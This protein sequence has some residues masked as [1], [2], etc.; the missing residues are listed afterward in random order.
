MTGGGERVRHSAAFAERIFTQRLLTLFL[1]GYIPTMSC[2]TRGRFPEAILQRTERELAGPGA[3]G[4]VDK[5]G[6]RRWSAGRRSALRH[7]A[8]AVSLYRARWVRYSRLQGVSNATPRAPPAAPSPSRT[9][10]GTGK[11]RTHCAARM[12]K[13]GCLK[14]WIRNARRAATYSPS[15]AGLTRASI[16]LRKGRSKRMDCRVKPGNDE[17]CFPAAM[18]RAALREALLRETPGSLRTMSFVRPRLCSAPGR[19]ERPAALRPGN[20]HRLPVPI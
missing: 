11:P 2:P 15:C 16:H 19:E 10:R 6:G 9:S 8:R 14:L 7:W 1:K 12:Q 4:M 20:G 13:F 3:P 5:A 17:S 18:Q